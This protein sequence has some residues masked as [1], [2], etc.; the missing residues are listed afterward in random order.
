MRSGSAAR[1]AG[2]LLAATALAFTTTR[3]LVAA[4]NLALQEGKAKEA[5]AAYQRALARAPGRP[6]ILFDLGLAEAQAGDPAAARDHLQAALTAGGEPLRAAI[7]YNVGTTYLAEERWG[8]AVQAFEA[9]LRADPTRQDA[10]ANLELARQRLQEAQEKKEAQKKE[11][12]GQ[13]PPPQGEAG[14]KGEAGQPQ[15]EPPPESPDGKGEEQAGKVQG[16]TPPAPPAADPGAAASPPAGPAG[17]PPPPEPGG[18]ESGAQGQPGGRDEPGP[19]GVAAPAPAAPRPDGGA[20]EPAG[21]RTA[22]SANQ[23]LDD[24]QRQ[25]GEVQRQVRARLVPVAPRRRAQDW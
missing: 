20:G 18:G 12:E 4:G 14:E 21:A 17:A 10:K 22:D 23:L 24:L 19:P 11:E 25:G 8:E 3:G 1:A 13:K 7:A 6:E 5:V 9:A 16:E 2:L 15:A